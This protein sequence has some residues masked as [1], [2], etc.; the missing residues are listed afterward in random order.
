M[1]IAI[2][3]GSFAP[4]HEARLRVAGRRG[5]SRGNRLVGVEVAGTQSDYRW[6]RTDEVSPDYT[7]L[8]LYPGA[9]YWTL[10]F[11]RV[12]RA[13]QRALDSVQPDVVVLPGWGFKEAIAGLS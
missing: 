1:V 7:R 3:Y 4:L 13:L 8:L 12:R 11:A 2:V 6:S 10:S 5:R 9:D